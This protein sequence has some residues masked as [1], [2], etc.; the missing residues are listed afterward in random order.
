MPTAALL[1][2]YVY[3]LIERL[4]KHLNTDIVNEKYRIKMMLGGD[5]M[6]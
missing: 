4:T 1:I 3:D 5:V 6:L 2:F